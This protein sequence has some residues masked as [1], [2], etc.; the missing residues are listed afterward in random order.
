MIGKQL[1]HYEITARLGRGGM[2]E[3]YEARDTRLGRAVAIKVFP[4]ASLAGDRDAFDRFD[5]EAKAIAALQHPNICALF[6]VGAAGTTRYLVME[7]IEG[8][9]LGERMQQ[10]PLST[11]DALRYGAQIAEALAVAHA[12]H[13]VHRDLKPSNVML[14]AGW[15]KVLDFGLAKVTDPQTS[16]AID[17][18]TQLE[19]S[20]H[21]I[22]GTAP[23]MSP[24]QTRGEPV[25]HRTDIWSFGVL[26][27]EMLAG[28]RMFAGTSPAE[29]LAAILK[30]PID[31]AALPADV[32]PP[33]RNL[34]ARLVE[35]DRGRRPAGMAE[36][37]AILVAAAAG[38]VAG[39]HVAP[40]EASRA[41]QSIV[42]L[43]FANSSPD[44]ANEYFSDGLTEEVI[45]DLSKVGA[46]RVISRTTAMRLK[47]TDKDL[48]AV[49]ELLDV[50]YALEG[51]VRKAGDSLRITAQLV[52]IPRDATIWSD[53]YTG[54][55]DDVFAIQE[56]VSRAIVAA[57]R[58]KLSADENR[59]L[60]ASKAPNAYAYDAY[61]RARKD[62]WSFLPERIDHAERELQHALTVVGDDPW[63]YC[64][65]SLAQWQRVNAG[66][67][68]DPRYLADAA[69]YARKVEELDPSSAQAPYLLGLITAQSGDAVGWV[70]HLTRAVAMD[71]HHPDACVWLAFGWTWVG[72][73]HRARPLF[74]KLLE[75]DPLFDYLHWGLGFEAHFAGEFA[76][77]EKCFE[78]ARELAP[79]HPGGAMV[80][81]QLFGSIGDIE[82]MTRLVEREVPDPLAHPLHTLTHILKHALLGDAAAANALATPEWEAKV[83]SD[84]QYTY[85]T[86]QAHALLGQNDE[87]LRWLERSIS[88]GF[89]CYPF[90]SERDPLLARLR[91]DPRFQELMGRLRQQWETFEARVDGASAG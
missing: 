51:S 82:R 13:I 73:P 53:K 86:A 59:H 87:A 46:L 80:L 9:T 24:E 67:S 14:A 65:L 41:D 10:Q 81:V 22:V 30:D 16:V 56:S 68:G 37:A 36:V 88:R 52:D 5:R 44:A 60:V 63:L 83:W 40:R 18:T 6:D 61:L 85:A 45:S 28:K 11:P 77:A 72:F 71:P 75:I 2:G 54:T 39:S 17:A 70:R 74:D 90:I 76:R 25:D 66:I 1:G 50:R 57:L 32:P 62:I 27:Y 7:R 26:L 49:A 4:D 29:I 43:P 38:S 34:I 33:V 35:R 31:L 15:I 42:V 79:D 19:T 21:V 58:I 48:T 3:V 91:A 78:R 47:G 23:Y 8:P 20:P 69:R 84:F 55:L 89:L 12:K 64:G